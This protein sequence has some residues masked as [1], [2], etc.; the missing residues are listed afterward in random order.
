MKSRGRAEEFEEKSRREKIR[1]EKESEE[2][3]CRCAKRWESR[4]TLCFFPMNCGSRGSKSRL[5]KAGSEPAGQMRDKKLH[6]NVVPSTFASEKAKN[7]SRSDH[8]WKLRCQKK[9]RCCGAKHMSKSKCTNHF[10]FGILLEVAVSKKCTLLW[11]EAHFFE[12]KMLK[13][14]TCP[15]HFWTFRCRFE[16]QAQGIV[17]LVK[18]EQNVKVFFGSSTRNS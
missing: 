5:A 14:T 13:N 18:S 16:W 12:V 6:A 9:E 11:R 4:K 8:F 3:R 2:R 17:D 10:S 7:N 15:R 1:E